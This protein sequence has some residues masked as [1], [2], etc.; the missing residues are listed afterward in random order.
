MNDIGE[1]VIEAYDS[2]R[3]VTDLLANYIMAECA[4]YVVYIVEADKELFHIHFCNDDRQMDKILVVR[5]DQLACIHHVLK[6]FLKN[7]C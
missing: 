3:K 4:D 6:D 2:Y 5:K 7:L 1:A